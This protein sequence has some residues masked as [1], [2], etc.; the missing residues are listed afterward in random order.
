MIEVPRV[1]IF[2]VYRQNTPQGKD[3][4]HLYTEVV[5]LDKTYSS[6]H[7]LLYQ[8]HV[9]ALTDSGNNYFNKVNQRELHQHAELI[10]C[11]VLSVD[12]QKK[13]ILL[14][15]KKTVRYRYLVI[16]NGDPQEA[17]Y[18]NDKDESLAAAFATLQDAIKLREKLERI[19]IVPQPSRNRRTKAPS[20]T[21]I[22]PAN[23]DAMKDLLQKSHTKDMAHNSF[24][25]S[26]LI[27]VQT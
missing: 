25:P 26:R 12:R 3:D 14:S 2:T 5:L 19:S 24:Q 27:E 18:G 17:V 16:L 15:N 22:V 11:E 8:I 4:N 6:T 1:A 20:A 23:L 21:Q 9:D 10:S 13:E 7:P